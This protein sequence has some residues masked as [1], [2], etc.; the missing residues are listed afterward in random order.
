MDERAILNMVDLI[1]AAATEDDHNTAWI[2]FLNMLDAHFRNSKSVLFLE[3]RKAMV[4]NFGCSSSLDQDFTKSY[5][6][7]YISV[8]PWTTKSFGIKPGSVYA[9]ESLIDTC[10]LMKTEFYGDWLRPQR[11]K[12]GIGGRILHEKSRIMSFSI[13]L[14]AKA[15]PAESAD[16]DML[17]QLMPHLQRAA[18]I[19][20][21][22]AHAKF[23]YD[24]AE[25][26]LD[27]LAIGVLLLDRDGKVFHVNER[28]AGI[29]GLRDGL[30]LDHQGMLSAALQSETKRLRSL[31]HDAINAGKHV[32]SSGGG[33]M[34]VSRIS[35]QQSFAIL[36]A[37]L[38]KAQ[39]DL[40][41]ART[42]C[43][44]FVDEPD[45]IRDIK[46]GVLM[47]LYGVTETE[48]RVM[49]ALVQGN[50]LKEIAA[51][52]GTSL[53]TV[54]TQVKNIFAKTE[55]ERQADLVRTVLSG[56]VGAVRKGMDHADSN[57]K[58]RNST[59]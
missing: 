13:L 7:H 52:H 26:V 41:L 42:A 23:L 58:G 1:Y 32:C 4:L 33:A 9:A 40:L 22:L 44:L 34:Q 46:L 17:R 51:K 53:N 12:Y 6:S 27:T 2:P 38:R 8:N 47:D 14:D 25:S 11:L 3:D 28:A 37:P 31:I 56:P 39:E 59:G 48:A 49:L 45:A 50:Q 10:E 21:Q 30:A 36:V 20:R 29:V 19:R 5:G 57:S 18:Q 24:T 35:G 43:V 54:K 16:L 15:G 55:T